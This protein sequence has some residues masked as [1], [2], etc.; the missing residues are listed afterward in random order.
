MDELRDLIS[1]PM[2]YIDAISEWISSQGIKDIDITQT[3]DF[4]QFYAT[5]KQAEALL[6]TTFKI[7][8]YNNG[9][10]TLIRAR[11]YSVPSNIAQFIDFVG[12]VVHFPAIRMRTSHPVKANL[13]T[14][15]ET[16]KKRY[17]ITASGKN[18]TNLQ[19]V[20]QFLG[21]YYS[22]AD[23]TVFQKLYNLLDQ[24]MQKVVGPNKPGQP[25]LEASLDSEY[26][27]A[28]AQNVSTWFY[29]TAGTDN[30]G[31]ETFIEWITL[32]NNETLA[33]YVLSVSYGDV[34]SSISL[35]YVLR[36]N[37][38]FQKAGTMGRSILFAS[39]DSGVGCTGS[40]FSPNFPASSPYVTTVGGTYM[41][42]T[43]EV[44]VSFSGGGFSNYF[45]QP[46]YQ[47]DAVTK[48]FMTSNLPP[49]S[50]YNASGRG[51]P[52][53]A[54][55][56]TDFTIVVGGSETAVDGTSCAA[57]TA[58][59]IIS[60][61]NDIRL[62]KGDPTLGFL[63]IWLYGT[64]SLSQ[65]AIYDVTKGNNP[66][67]NCPGFRAAVGWDPV[68]GLGTLNYAVLSTIV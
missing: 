25:G 43:E 2:Y 65:N 67:G 18:S 9:E 8:Q 31:Q 33:P 41:S 28:V 12:G 46:S 26:I 52:D 45:S 49:A 34:E 24:P 53:I 42:G 68:T 54:A 62:N 6:Q 29:Y 55:F 7:Y 48:Y 10:I 5:I 35:S 19:A 47:N 20:N 32:V 56:A 58:S 3:N 4:L 15:P 30:G 57:P 23:L 63:N 66:D 59:G 50:Y 16:I 14:T 37:T 38:E 1:P 22:P 39:G 61:L 51:Y 40:K 44:G 21:C 13:G 36:C 17:N 27:M 60:L 64:A 11:R